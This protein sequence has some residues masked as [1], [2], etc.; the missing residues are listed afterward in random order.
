M[1]LLHRQLV[2]G[3]DQALN[4]LIGCNRLH[5]FRHIGE[6]NSAVKEM[7][8]LDQDSDAGGALVEAA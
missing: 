1:E 3:E 4:A 6:S 8:G 5:D 7:I 2:R